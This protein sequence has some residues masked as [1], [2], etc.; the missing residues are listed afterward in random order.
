MIFTQGELKTAQA[1]TAN[2][3]E[4]PRSCGYIVKGGKR[5]LLF[6]HKDGNIYAVRERTTSEIF[7]NWAKLGGLVGYDLVPNSQRI[8]DCNGNIYADFIKDGFKTCLWV[9]DYNDYIQEVTR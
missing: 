1:R 4:N 5:F 6:P 3:P 2:T 7:R 9:A 8:S